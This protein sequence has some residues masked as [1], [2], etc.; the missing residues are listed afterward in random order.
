MTFPT[1]YKKTSSGAIQFWTIYVEETLHSGKYYDICTEYGQVGTESPQKTFDTISK[2]KNQ[3]KKNETSIHKQAE[4]EAKA[5]WEKQKKKGYVESIE[6]A[7]LEQLD[8]SI[9]GGILPMLAHKFSE[10]GHKIKY[11]CYVQPKLDGIRCIAILK[12]GKCTIWS[13]T[14]KRI[15]S[16]PHI[17]AEIEKHFVA[18]IVLDGELY[19]H[20]FKNEFE[21]IVSM[22]RQEEPHER[23]TDVQYHIYDLIDDTPFNKRFLKLTNAFRI[24]KPVLKHIFPVFTVMAEEENNIEASF[25]TMS[26]GMGYEGVMVRNADSLYVN[27]R[28]YDLQ[29]VKEFDDGEFEIVGIEEGRGKLAGHVG[30]FVCRT[31]DGKR[32]L[33]KMSGEISSLNLSN[34]LDP[35]SYVGK[36]LTVQYQGLTSY[37]IPRFPIGK[38][39]RDYE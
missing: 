33:A 37:G 20:A 28:S 38:S 22:V 11:P 35:S 3:G 27:K 24:G 18:D 32:F 14:R 16:M 10:Q 31:K 9:E 1:L 25:N 7:E 23:H 26:K 8:S 12:D 2:G 17:V 6:A 34:F 21:H 29:K 15:T 36:F 19:N 4:S 13:R 5:K 30:A 39:I